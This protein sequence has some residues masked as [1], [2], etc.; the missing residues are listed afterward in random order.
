MSHALLIYLLIFFI[1]LTMT[2]VGKGGGNFYVV[3]LALVD[4]PMHTAA[5]TGQFIL[6]AASLAAMMIFHKNRSVSWKLALLIGGITAAAA[7]F[8]GILSHHFSALT[9]KVIFAIMLIIAGAVMLIPKSRLKDRDMMEREDLPWYTLIARSSEKTYHLNMLIVLP[10]TILT[11]FA[12]GMVGVSGG[13]FLVPLLV[14][15]AGVPMHTAVG[16]ASILI[17]ATSGMGFIGHA[18]SGHFDPSLALPLAVMTIIGGLLGGRFAL[19][20]RPRHL[21][22][23][24][25]YTN[26]LAAVMMFIQLAVQ[27]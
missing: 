7:F 10:V 17:A 21:K 11:G 19:K 9:L 15:A 22:Q 27:R 5:A 26:W 1:A 25:A 14:L 2:M 20:S 18:A 8:G 3:V 12:S 6:C 24:F 13:S 16:T 23:I 4:I